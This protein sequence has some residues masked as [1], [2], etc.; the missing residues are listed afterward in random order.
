[1]PAGPDSPIHQERS[2]ERDLQA[3]EVQRPLLEAA[4]SYFRNQSLF[5]VLSNS[6]AC[7]AAYLALIHG[8][9]VTSPPIILH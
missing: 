5:H 1:M 6:C 7:I 2:A 3:T 8:I 4:L 9:L